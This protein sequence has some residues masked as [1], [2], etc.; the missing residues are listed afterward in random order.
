MSRPSSPRDGSVIFESP[1]EEP[2]RAFRPAGTWQAPACLGSRPLL[3]SSR[4]AQ[5]GG[6]PLLDRSRRDGRGDLLPQ[7]QSQEAFDEENPQRLGLGAHLQAESK[8]QGEATLRQVE[9]GGAERP[10]AQRS[11]EH[12]SELQSRENL[13]CR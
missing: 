7:P 2:G 9:N 12:T 13:V 5:C 11:E 6:C 10:G 1:P 4:L 3:L 8:E